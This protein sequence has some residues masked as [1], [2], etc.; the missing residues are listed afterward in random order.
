[1]L[2]EQAS[3]K[4]FD[5]FRSG[6]HCAESISRAIVELH[7]GGADSS[8]VQRFTAGFVGGIGGTHQ[9]TCGAL[10]GGIVAIGCLRGRREAGQDNREVKELATEFRRR[11]VAE[12]GSS[13]CQVLLDR[14]SERE[15]GFD[16]KKL[17]AVAAGMLSEMLAERGL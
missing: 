11:F 6:F 16:C 4:A 10:T 17:T 1:M 14:L 3:E 7:G 2:K 15:D 5:Y 9:E 13:N 12:F 8:E